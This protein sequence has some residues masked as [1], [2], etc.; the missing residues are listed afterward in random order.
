MINRNLKNVCLTN[1]EIF[2]CLEAMDQIHISEKKDADTR[3]RIRRE[4]EKSLE[5]Q[6]TQFQWRSI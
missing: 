1:E 3:L 4:L 5:H 2:M 6:S